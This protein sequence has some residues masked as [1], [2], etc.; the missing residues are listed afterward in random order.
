VK[1]AGFFRIIWLPG[2][3]GG[4]LKSQGVPYVHWTFHGR[5]CVPR[6]AGAGGGGLPD[7]GPRSQGRTGGVRAPP[8]LAPRDREA[9]SDGLGRGE[10]DRPDLGPAR[11]HGQVPDRDRSA[12]AGT[13]PDGVERGKRRCIAHRLNAFSGVLR[14]RGEGGRIHSV[15]M[16]L[17]NCFIFARFL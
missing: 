13:R 1:R 12:G 5:V 10:R 15:C 9:A 3:I 8:V 2:R 17:G 11:G 16:L 7:D 14:G 4:R 6:H